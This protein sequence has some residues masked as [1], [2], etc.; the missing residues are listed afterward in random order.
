MVDQPSTQPPGTPQ[1]ARRPPRLEEQRDGVFASDATWRELNLTVSAEV[2]RSGR[3]TRIDVPENTIFV[4][5]ADRQAWRA[6][7]GGLAQVFANAT[8]LPYDDL[9]STLNFSSLNGDRPMG[10]YSHTVDFGPQGVDASDLSVISVEADPRDTL[11][12][13]LKMRPEQ[14]N[15]S[16][17]YIQA[18]EP[19]AIAHEIRHRS[20][21]VADT[22]LVGIFMAET[23]A[24][25]APLRQY[26][27]ADYNQFILDVRAIETIH[28]QISLRN[29]SNGDT[30]ASH[31]WNEEYG[32]RNPTFE[33]VDDFANAPMNLAQETYSYIHRMR[34]VLP[35]DMLERMR[36]ADNNPAQYLGYMQALNET[37]KIDAIPGAREYADKY[38]AAMQRLAGPDIIQAAERYRT[39]MVAT[40]QT[41]DQLFP[42]AQTQTGPQAAPSPPAVTPGL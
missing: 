10:F 40:I 20:Q 12:R 37:G 19:Y 39:D 22:S 34:D 32:I 3:A 23:D 2:S 25:L 29:V 33:E 6:Q 11:F 36:I 42:T 13:F 4:T 28:S 21:S 31:L 14:T 5:D 26:F 15:I 27:N 24:D 9:R 18:F 17:A 7:S 38:F 35:P 30:H 41:Y 16:E 1:P 8:G